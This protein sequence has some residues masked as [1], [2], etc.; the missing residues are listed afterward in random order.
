MIILMSFKW[1]PGF[2]FFQLSLAWVPIIHLSLICWGLSL[3]L[4]GHNNSF[5]GE[6]LS[7]RLV[8]LVIKLLSF[9]FFHMNDCKRSKTNSVFGLQTRVDEKSLLVSVISVPVS[10]SS[11]KEVQ[12]FSTKLKTVNR[13]GQKFWIFFVP[14]TFLLWDFL[15]LLNLLLF[16]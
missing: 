4:F 12:F 6:M 13:E 7:W 11:K 10:H 16:Y 15:C 2:W 1:P 9:V 3:P 5:L 8:M 14:P